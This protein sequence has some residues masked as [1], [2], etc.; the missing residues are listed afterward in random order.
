[1]R[2]VTLTA[3]ALALTVAASAAQAGSPHYLPY[4]H[5]QGMG[6][7]KL[8]QYVHV[9]SACTLRSKPLSS[10]STNGVEFGQYNTGDT[11]SLPGL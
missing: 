1:M 11:K 4:N 5:I 2:K 3:M 9:L 6:D 8:P 7:M 10:T